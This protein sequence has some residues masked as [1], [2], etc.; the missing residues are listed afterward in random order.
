MI[1]TFVF[2]N[3]ETYFEMSSKNFILY[4]GLIL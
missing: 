2:M 3:I 4:Y 1:I